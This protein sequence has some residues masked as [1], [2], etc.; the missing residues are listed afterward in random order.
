MERLQTQLISARN[1]L[2]AAE[3]R[4]EQKQRRLDFLESEMLTYSQAQGPSNGPSGI[5]LEEAVQPVEASS[6]PFLQ[7]LQ[8][9]V[10]LLKVLCVVME[11]AFFF[12]GIGHIL[13]PVVMD[14]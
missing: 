12:T 14:L 11:H 4:L 9:Q 8:R 5:K 6:M 3:T 10:S 7:E 2:G 1:N 13:T